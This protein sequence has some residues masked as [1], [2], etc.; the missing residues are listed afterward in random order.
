M[1]QQ[2]YLQTY[3][4]AEW[5]FVTTFD[6][7][8]TTSDQSLLCADPE[9]WG[10]ISSIRWDLTPCFLDLWLVFVAAW[11]IVGGAGAIWYL[12]RRTSQ[13][14]KKNWHFYAKLYVQVQ[15]TVVTEC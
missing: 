8:W 15:T 14:V 11:G 7:P 13:D 2:A 3:E 10:P 12:S 6:S 4:T 5:D 1:T 9:G